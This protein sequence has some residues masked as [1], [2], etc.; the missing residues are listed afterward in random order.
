MKKTYWLGTV[1]KVVKSLTK[2]VVFFLLL[3]A[4]GYWFYQY[5]LTAKR[6]PIRVVKIHATWSNLTKQNLVKLI[7]PN[8]RNGFFHSHINL[9]QS[10]I[11]KLPWILN[12]QVSRQWQDTINIKLTEKNPLAYWNK[13]G[14]ITAQGEV[15][16]PQS[17]PSRPNSLPH[18]YG[19]PTKS[20]FVLK[21]YLSI[22]SLLKPLHHKIIAYKLD[23][24]LSREVVLEGGVVI[25][26]GSRNIFS[27]IN[28]LLTVFKPVFDDKYKQIAYID[29]RYSHGLAVQWR[30]QL[31]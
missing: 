19:E 7:A 29:L 16:Y 15:F 22:A 28:R 23:K 17:L 3:L 11:E 30:N 5:Y 25:K 20:Q 31:G 10:E 24:H 2:S 21:E 9:V 27:R 6:Y 18:L 1:N 12:A 8:L 4:V 13:N 26:L 14:L